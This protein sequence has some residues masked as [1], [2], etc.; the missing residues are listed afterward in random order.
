MNPPSFC[1][2]AIEVM[3]KIKGFGSS[4]ANVDRPVDL[5]QWTLNPEHFFRASY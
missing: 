1:G 4:G 5:S 2:S 3:R